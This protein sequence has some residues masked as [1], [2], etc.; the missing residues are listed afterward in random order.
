MSKGFDVELPV[1][2]VTHGAKEWY[3]DNEDQFFSSYENG[4]DST[5]IRQLHSKPIDDNGFGLSRSEA[6]ITIHHVPPNTLVTVEVSKDNLE[7][8]NRS[9]ITKVVEVLDN[10]EEKC[11]LNPIDCDSNPVV[12]I[13]HGRSESWRI[14]KDHLT[15]K[16][17]YEIEAYETGA[18]A[19][20]TIR[21]ILQSMLDRSSFALLVFTKEDE[22][23]DKQMRARQNVIHETGLFQGKLGFNRAIV[24]LENGTEEFSNIQGVE[25][26]RFEKIQ[27]VLGEVLATLKREFA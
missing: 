11:R 15:D 25:Q 22:M 16:H 27:E 2:S 19:G 14:L 13:G 21:D 4:D 18:R 6:A 1:L 3:F 9:S 17:G 23:A 26:I 5:Y 8:I 7:P 24:L 20:H 10:D 12:F